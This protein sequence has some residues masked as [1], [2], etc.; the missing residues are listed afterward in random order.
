MVDTGD[1][2][3]HRPSGEKWVVAFVEDDHLY[4]CGWPEGRARLDDCELLEP[5]TPERRAELLAN[6]AA[7]TDAHDARHRYAIRRLSE[8]GAA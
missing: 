5:A 3:L 1:V 8:R 7:M 4:W 6:I 2:V